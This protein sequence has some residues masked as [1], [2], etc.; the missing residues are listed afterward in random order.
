MYSPLHLHQLA[1]S[2]IFTEM[3]SDTYFQKT[4]IL[5]KSDVYMHNVCIDC[6]PLKPP[7]IY[8]FLLFSSTYLLL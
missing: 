6:D 3:L 7:N 4:G 8:I 2:Q 5:Y 1:E